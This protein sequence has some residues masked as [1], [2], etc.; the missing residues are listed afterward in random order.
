MSLEVGKILPEGIGEVQEYIDMC[1]YAVGLSRMVGGRIMPSESNAFLFQ[2]G[3]PIIRVGPEHWL[4]EQWN[5]LGL[6]GIITAF[7]FPVAVFGWNHTLSLVCGNCTVWYV[8]CLLDSIV[9]LTLLP[10][11]T[12]A[13]LLCLDCVCCIA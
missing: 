1:D 7:N 4:L 6:V 11:C 3:D 8:W 5:P 10:M 13:T 12:I 2:T 9:A